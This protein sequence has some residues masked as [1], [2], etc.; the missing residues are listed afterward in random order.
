MCKYCELKN[1]ESIGL[2]DRRHEA[3]ILVNQKMNTTQKMKDLLNS[4]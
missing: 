1:G 4:N 3:Y 2:T